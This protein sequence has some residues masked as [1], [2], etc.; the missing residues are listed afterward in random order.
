MSGS[1]SSSSS[2]SRVSIPN[3]MKKMI[4]NIKEITG[5]H[6]EDEIYAMLKECSMDP[7]ET[8]Q[9]LLFQG[10]FSFPVLFFFMWVHLGFLISCC[11]FL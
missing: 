1:G 8:A 11:P 7:N 3:N 10:I 6:S 9:R 2:S 4:Q 5:N